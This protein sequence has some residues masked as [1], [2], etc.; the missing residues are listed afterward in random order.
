M[1]PAKAKAR[2]NETFIVQASLTIVTYDC[3]NIFIVQATACN[4]EVCGLSPATAVYAVREE[5]AKKVSDSDKHSSLLH[6]K[7]YLL[8]SIH[9][10][11]NY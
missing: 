6:Q 10:S 5:R 9:L 3:Q 11:K 4:P 1:T 7:R 8:Y 2:A